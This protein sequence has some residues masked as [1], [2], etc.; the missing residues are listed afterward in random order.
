M[1]GSGT[2]KITA[3]PNDILF[4]GIGNMLAEGRSVTFTA[5]GR[6]MFPFI[7]GGR[8]KVTLIRKGDVRKGDIVLARTPEACILHRVIRISGNDLT[9]MGDGNIR[10]KEHCRK[11]DILGTVSTIDRNG[12]TTDCSSFLEKLKYTIWI[13]LIPVRRP[14]LWIIW[15][16][17]AAGA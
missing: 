5:K 10:Q 2:D 14:V 16:T 3:I 9:L 1:P 4:D 15:K 8:D 12:K 6:S 17:G 13:L 11:E 7:K